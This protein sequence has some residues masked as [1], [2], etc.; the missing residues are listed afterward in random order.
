MI[1]PIV[2][3]AFYLDAFCTASN[4]ESLD[5]YIIFQHSRQHFLKYIC[6][7]FIQIC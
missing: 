7:K 3:T 4:K 6:W 5:K 1:G 2:V